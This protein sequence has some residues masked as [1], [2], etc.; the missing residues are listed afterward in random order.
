MM[1]PNN[2]KQLA[3]TLE[4]VIN[5]PVSEDEVKATTEKQ[6]NYLTSLIYQ[7]EKGDKRSIEIIKSILKKRSIY[8]ERI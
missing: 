1:N 5:E 2:Y 7:W 6:R 3:E 8:A 4:E